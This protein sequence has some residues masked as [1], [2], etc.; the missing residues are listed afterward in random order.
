MQVKKYIASD[1]QEA[2]SMIKKDLGPKAVIVSTRKV[3]KGGGAFGL[4][5][6]EVLEVVA[7]QEDAVQAPQVVPKSV[8]PA[9]NTQKNPFQGLN[10]LAPLQH[11]I[12]DLKDVI[13][14]LRKNQRREINDEGN[15]NHM[16]YE[17]TELKSMINTL[18]SQSGFLKEQDLHDHLIAL[19]QQLTF[20]GVEEKF[21]KRLVE[22]VQ[23][24]IPGDEINNFSYVKLYVA[25][26]FMQVVKLDETPTQPKSPTDKKPTVLTFIGPTGVGKTTTVAKIASIEKL[27]NPNKKIALITIDT[28]R[29]AAVQQLKEYARI[30]KVPI[31]VVNSQ[32]QLDNSLEEF[33]DKDLVL[34]DTAGRSQR[35]EIQ[36]SELRELFENHPEFKNFLVLSSTTKDSDLIEITKRFG[37]VAIGGVIF[38]KLDESTTYGAIFNHSIRF[39]LPLVYLTTGQNVPEDLEPASRERLIDLLLNISGE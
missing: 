14:D 32:E 27:Q 36:M 38:T 11:E 25:R 9:Q 2:I 16:R 1:M 23:K 6:Q 15:I 17:L 30:I 21:A 10:L 26:M 18:I 37:S 31:R 33:K 24:K 13:N 34:I 7:A 3:K 12:G 19:Y 39:K 28:F 35:D 5:G 20:N 29:I 8:E 4:F 22:E